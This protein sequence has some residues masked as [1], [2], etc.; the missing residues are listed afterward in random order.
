MRFSFII[1]CVFALATSSC[2]S[3]KK[4]L[5]LEGV[6]DGLLRDIEEKKDNIKSLEEEKENLI[7]T[8]EE[9][10]TKLNGTISGLKNDVSTAEAATEAAKKATEA[11]E[12]K[13]TSLNST[14]DGAFTAYESSGLSLREENDIIYLDVAPV[15]FKSG[16]IRMTSDDKSVLDSLATMLAANP[17]LEVTAE[18]HADDDGILGGSYRDNWDLSYRRADAVVRQLVKAGVSPSQIGSSARGEYKPVGDNET[19]EGQALNR[20]VVFRI[21]PKMGD[22]Y[23]TSKSN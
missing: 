19:E 9:E 11:V 14:I 7:A 13:V 23:N 16:S 6:R 20:R 2:V 12:A 1:L 15:L 18:G 8:Y 10:K 22:I 4:F 5:E 17:N 3:K 21:A